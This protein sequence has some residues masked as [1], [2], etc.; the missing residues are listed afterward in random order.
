VVARAL[1]QWLAGRPDE[2][3]VFHD[4][5][6]LNDVSGARLRPVSLG[7]T[8]IDHLVLAGSGWLMIDAKGCGAGSLQVRAGKGVLVRGDSAQVPQPWMDDCSAYSRAGVPYRLTEGKAGIPVWVVPE[9]TAYSHPSF[10]RARFLTR[11]GCVLNDAE[12]RAG[13]L[14]A[15]LPIPADPADPRDVQRLRAYV[16]VPD[17]EYRLDQPDVHEGSTHAVADA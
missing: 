11:A 13:E 1:H 17:V 4:L 3:H 7:G 5:V 8:S 12:V 6:G 10:R 14:D 9:A 15:C 2:V 16:S